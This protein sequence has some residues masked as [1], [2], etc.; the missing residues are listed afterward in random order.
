MIRRP[1]RSTLFP[2]TTLFRSTLSQIVAQELALPLDRVRIARPEIGMS[3]Y[4]Q[5]TSASR[6]TTLMG[7]A[8]FRAARDVRDQLVAIGA[9]QLGGEA[10]AG[11]P[12]EGALGAPTGRR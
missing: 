5:A 3:P 12:G 10:T 1:P 7:L 2:Y 6:S 9:R 11:T 8:V 4:D